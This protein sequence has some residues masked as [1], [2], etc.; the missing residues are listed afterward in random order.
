MAA[1]TV[2]DLLE[3]DAPT[4]I[5]DAGVARFEKRAGSGDALAAIDAAED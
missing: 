1:T 3:R 2:A 5:L 4:V